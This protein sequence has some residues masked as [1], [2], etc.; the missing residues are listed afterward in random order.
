MGALTVSRKQRLRTLENRIRKNFESFVQTGMDLKEIRDEELYK[1]DGFEKW[2]HYLKQ[3][4]GEHFGIERSQVKSL[5]Q[6]AEIRPKLPELNLGQRAG[7]N[8]GW[9][10]RAV[11]EFGRLVP[12]RND[13][14]RKKDYA[15]L[16][17]SDAAR[18]AKAAVTLAGDGPLTSTHVRKA[19]DVELGIDRS[20][21]ASETKRASGTTRKLEDYIESKIGQIEGII[22]NLSEVPV[23]SW[24]LL[25][26]SQP[27]LAERLATACDEL[28]GLMRS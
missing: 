13:D 19:V 5:I 10:Q 25:G 6:C 7:P 21:K 11:Q 23:D 1:E 27:G 26:D 4:V 14:P 17:K 22:E 18:V 16:R 24:T 8:D 12:E 20:A 9:S 2:S 15:A 3:R 28:A